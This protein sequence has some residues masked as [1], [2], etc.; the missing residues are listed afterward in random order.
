MVAARARARAREIPGPG[1]VEVESDP[2]CTSAEAR[3][4]EE[5]AST[6]GI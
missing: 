1:N 6:A 4:N 2:P 5:S 3:S